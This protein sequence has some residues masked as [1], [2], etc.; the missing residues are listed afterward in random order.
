MRTAYVAMEVIAWFVILPFAFGTLVTG[1]IQSIGIP[2]VLLALLGSGKTYAV[3]FCNQR[4]A[5]ADEIN[6]LF[7]RHGS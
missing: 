5:A 6:W 1:F 2:W 7:G 3:C 4:L